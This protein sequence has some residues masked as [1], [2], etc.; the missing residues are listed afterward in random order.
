MVGEGRR[1]VEEE[2]EG[3]DEERE[4]DGE[5]R[6]G[7][8]EGGSVSHQLT[9]YSDHVLVPSS[10]EHRSWGVA[11]VPPNTG[12][13]GSRLHQLFLE[14]GQSPWKRKRDPRI[15]QLLQLDHPKHTCRQLCTASEVRDRRSERG[16]GDRGGRG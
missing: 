13:Q 11:G 14:P 8:G 7:G 5:E 16:G 15:P 10:P 12:P 6:E 4:G 9:A 3:G 1:V 2:R